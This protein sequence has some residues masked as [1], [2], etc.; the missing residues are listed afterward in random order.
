MQL[1]GFSRRHTAAASSSRAGDAAVEDADAD[2]GDG[3]G[4]S[5]NALIFALGRVRR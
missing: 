3:D 5:V 1:S 4:D 2:E